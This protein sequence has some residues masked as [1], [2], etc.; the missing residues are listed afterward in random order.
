MQILKL[1]VFCS[2]LSLEAILFCDSM[3]IDA[4]A[5]EKKNLYISIFQLSNYVQPSFTDSDSE[6]SNH[7]TYSD[8]S[9]NFHN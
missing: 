6:I 7:I 8:S 2:S 1:I 9:T 3:W 5:S 4:N